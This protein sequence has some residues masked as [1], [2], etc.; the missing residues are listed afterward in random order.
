MKQTATI[1]NWTLKRRENGDFYLVGQVVD[2]PRQSDFEG[3]VQTTTRVINFDG[4]GNQA[5]TLNTIYTLG[6][7][8]SE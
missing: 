7:P 2:H 5:E 3:S 1:N 8:A 4:P 6:A